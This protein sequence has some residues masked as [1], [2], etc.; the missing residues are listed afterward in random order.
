M[1]DAYKYTSSMYG[2][3]EDCPIGGD[4]FGG[5]LVPK[6]GYWRS[7]K[8]SSQLHK[9]SPN[10][11][12][13]LG[14]KDSRCEIG[15][16]GILCQSCSKFNGKYYSKSGTGC[17]ICMDEVYLILLTCFIIVAFLLFFY[18]FLR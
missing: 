15:Y 8:N 10:S 5:V 11:E 4:C 18:F 2:K 13:C 17:N 3:C 7:D 12:S 14:G 9:C 1:C 16:G 6:P